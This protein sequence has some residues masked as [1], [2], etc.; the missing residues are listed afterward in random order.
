MTESKIPRP[1]V[2]I[3][4]S[5]E[6]VAIAEALFTCLSHTTEPTLWT[7]RLFR[8]GR[9][10]LEELERQLKRHSFAVLVATPD[11]EIFK[12]G[13]TAQTVRDNL[14]VEFGLF[15]GAIGRRRT[16]FVC[17]SEPEIELPSDLL[18][19]IHARYNAARARGDSSER[20]AAVEV[21][22]QQVKEVIA[23][24]WRSIQQE[25]ES[26][27]TKLRASKKGLALAR[28]N[29]VA[30]ELRDALMTVQREGFAAFS[31]EESFEEIKRSAAEKVREIAES[32]H[33]E[34]SL[35]G[36]EGE[37]IGLTTATVDALL[38]LPFPRELAVSGGAARE[39]ALDI[40]AGALSSFLSGADPL[41][42]LNK[43]ASEEAGSRIAALK[44]RYAEWWGG[45]SG[46]LQSSTVRLQDSLF[47]KAVDLA[48]LPQEFGGNTD[49]S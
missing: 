5:A 28:L 41:G 6:G 48:S 36:V 9:Y 15:A 40:G 7:H 3:G 18:G 27:S 10:P 11:D 45:H 23:E 29:G 13:E 43:V 2:F 44:A 30:I 16:F 31:D 39:K 12:R 35:V 37:L 14:L 38:D 20:A 1:R 8:A 24:E 33:E 22:C 46:S 47:A 25:A 32:F 26:T 34:A 21:A 19:I 17:P 42:H 4:S 49:S